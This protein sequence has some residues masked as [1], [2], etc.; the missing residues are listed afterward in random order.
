MP[1]SST[2]WS[3]ATP[4]AFNRSSRSPKKFADLAHDIGVNRVRLHRLRRALRV[5]ANVTGAEFR[6]DPPHRVL[7]AVGGHV[8]DDARARRKRGARDGGFHRVNRKRN[9]DCAGQLFDDR[10]DP[11]QFLGLAHR[12]GARAGGF[13][14][15]VE[16][17]RALRDQFQ[18]VGHGGVRI[19][20]LSAVGKRVRA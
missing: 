16:N 13:A 3:A 15:D 10:H 4:Q 1:T 2:T 9:F 20:K 8:V 7:F 18:R 14:A 19:E 17:F 6:H 11:A 12:L 5:H